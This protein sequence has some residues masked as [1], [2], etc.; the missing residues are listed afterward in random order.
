M[1]KKIAVGD[2]MTKNFVSVNPGTNLLDCAKEF[3]KQRVN[4]LVIIK[5]KKLVGIITQHDILWAITKKPCLDLRKVLAIDIATKKVAV[6]KPSADI[7]QAF[8]KMKKYG[9]RRLPVMSRGEIVGL[10]TLKD[11]LAIEPAFYTKSGDLLEIREEAE[12]LKK[13]TQEETVSDG[14][15]EE[16]NT[17]SELLKV[18]GRF[19]CPECREDLY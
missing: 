17:Y 1:F 19:L 13:A 10:L 16:C 7:T 14:L 18:E 5:D 15:C 3:V 12:K 4:G 6:I 2:I 8:Q 9:F 11:V